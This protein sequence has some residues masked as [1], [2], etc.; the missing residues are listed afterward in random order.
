MKKT[1]KP[2]VR[3]SA[4]IGEVSDTYIDPINTQ[5]SECVSM[6]TVGKDSDSELFKLIAERVFGTPSGEMP[7]TILRTR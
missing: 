4:S 7:E 2:W 5:L 3:P 6:V 1:T